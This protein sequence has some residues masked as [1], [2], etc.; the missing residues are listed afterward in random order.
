MST[1]KSIRKAVELIKSLLPANLQEMT[2]ER[3]VQHLETARNQI[4]GI[5][6][7]LI[8]EARWNGPIGEWVKAQLD[9]LDARLH[10]LQDAKIDALLEKVESDLQLQG[11]RHEAA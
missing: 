9:E 8:A 11:C 6:W 4:D 1:D 10:P 3:Q 7:L 5:S 2:P